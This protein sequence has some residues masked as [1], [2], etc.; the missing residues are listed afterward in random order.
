MNLIK[1]LWEVGNSNFKRPGARPRGPGASRYVHSVV[2]RR[3]RR[4]IKG[5][6]FLD[7]IFGDVGGSNN[8]GGW[9]R[10]VGEGRGR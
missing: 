2:R 9:K 8:G 6:H 3:R 5:R 7:E 4:R 1:L 10:K